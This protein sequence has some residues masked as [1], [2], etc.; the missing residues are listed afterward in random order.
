MGKTKGLFRILT[1]LVCAVLLLSASSCGKKPDT[2]EGTTPTA[3]RSD[4]IAT[5]QG[6]GSVTIGEDVTETTETKSP[7][8]K[9]DEVTADATD[10][11]DTTDTSSVTESSADTSA[12]RDPVQTD[13]PGTTDPEDN[14]SPIILGDGLYITSAF[15]YSGAYVEDGTDDQVTK[16][17]AAAI[18]NKGSEDIRI[19]T[20]TLTS[21]EG[22]TYEFEL[23]TLLAGDKMTVLEKN[24]KVMKAESM[25]YTCE[26]TSKVLFTEK[27]ATCKDQL[28][29]LAD[30]HDL[31]VKN[32]SGRTL[33]N[34][35]VYY[36]TYVD[37]CLRG[38]I[39]YTLE[40]PGLAPGKD[41]T[42][43]SIHYN[44]DT[45]RVMFV[46]YAE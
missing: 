42:V 28:V 12:K 21:F 22:E 37:G 9:T 25:S 24:R 7:T 5:D 23:T 36:K 18:E 14:I 15:A 29:F 40:F 19:M 10:S 6:D 13:K 32:V 46:T 1:V 2:E 41:A 11:D 34:G 35:R 3:E 20:F 39:T 8:E 17:A 26:I 44:G 4:E 31:T 38:G 43:S 27:P 33:P 30:G 45:S 16:V